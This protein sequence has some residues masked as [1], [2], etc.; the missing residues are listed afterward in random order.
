[1]PFYLA[2]DMVV[3]I[4]P[5][6]S[7]MGNIPQAPGGTNMRFMTIQRRPDATCTVLFQDENNIP[8]VTITLGAGVFGPIDLATLPGFADMFQYAI[9]NTSAFTYPVVV[10][11]AP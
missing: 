1:M 3:P 5:G 11:F 8:L 6:G 10:N 7:L 4:Q 2:S 9:R